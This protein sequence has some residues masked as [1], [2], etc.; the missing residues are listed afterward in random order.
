MD[1]LLHYN[2]NNNTQNEG[3]LKHTIKMKSKEQDNCGNS[4]YSA[5]CCNSFCTFLYHTH[6]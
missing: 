1:T 4:D 5:P 6:T 2:I 3:T